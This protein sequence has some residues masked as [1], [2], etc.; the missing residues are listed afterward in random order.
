MKKIFIV[1]AVAAAIVLCAAASRAQTAIKADLSSLLSVLT[2]NYDAGK[3]LGDFNINLY[4]IDGGEVTAVIEGAD[5]KKVFEQKYPCIKSYSLDESPACYMDS[6]S[7]K[8]SIKPYQVSDG[9]HTLRLFFKDKEFFTL[10]YN[11]FVVVQYDVKNIYITGDWDKMALIELSSQPAVRAT[12][13]SGDPKNCNG[14]G[15]SLQ[16]QLYRNGEFAAKGHIE[17][18]SFE[19]CSTN[20]VSFTLF[21][22]DANHFTK[23]LT[24]KDITGA[25]GAYELKYFKNMAVAKTYA[26]AVSGGKITS[27][28]SGVQA[29][30]FPDRLTSYSADPWVYIK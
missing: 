8:E 30:L 22:E 4:G 28:P 5:G 19:A 18:T 25:D 26:F 12:I 9:R 16:A 15:A 23:W 14:E 27:V 1:M 11:L 6:T 21:Y 7:Q 2:Y 29:G 20:A 24:A 10:N 3:F 17:G 13:Y